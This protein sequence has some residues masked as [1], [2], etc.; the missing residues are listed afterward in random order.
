[1][2]FRKPL[3]NVLSVV[4]L[5]VALLVSSASHAEQ[6]RVDRLREI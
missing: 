6:Q 1:M 2:I 5:L 4:T 3:K